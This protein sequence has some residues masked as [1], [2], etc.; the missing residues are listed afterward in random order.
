ME[1][2]VGE[3]ENWRRIWRHCSREMA[4]REPWS[5]LD[6]EDVADQEEFEL[7]AGR[8]LVDMEGRK[9]AGRHT[10]ASQW[11]RTLRSKSMGG[12]FLGKKTLQ[13]EKRDEDH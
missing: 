9:P 13:R 3:L 10:M 2:L 4:D 6:E 12:P 1:E 5:G 8:D 11:R 7:T